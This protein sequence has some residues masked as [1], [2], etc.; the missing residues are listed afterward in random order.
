MTTSTLS[1]PG[2]TA[3]SSA[4]D[5]HSISRATVA[6]SLGATLVVVLALYTVGLSASGY[7]NSFYSA[8]AQA[9]SMSWKAFFFGSLDPGNA[10]TVDKTPGALWIMALSVRLFGLSSWSILLPQALMGVATAAILYITVRRTLSG[11]ASRYAGAPSPARAHWA[12]IVA[13]LAFALTPSATLM[14]RF[15]NPDA[16]M[17]LCYVAASAMTLRA[18]E[19]ASRWKLVG[20]GA[21]VGLGFLAKMLQAF[22]IL[23][24]LVLAYAV[25]APASWRKKVVDLLAAFAAMVVAFGW[26]IAIVELMPASARPYVGGSQ[27]NSVLELTFGYNGLG[28]LNGNET[29]SV[30]G[31]GGTGGRWGTTGISRMFTTVSGEMVSWL[32]PAALVLAVAGLLLLGRRAWATTLRSGEGSAATRTA[33]ALV[34]FTSWLVVN[35]LVFSL[36]AGIYHDYYTVALSPAIAGAFALGG[37]VAWS[38]RDTFVGRLGLA[39]AALATC[40]WGVALASVAGG[41]YLMVSVAAA[42]V[43]LLAAVAFLLGSRLP[44]AL[45]S[46]VVGL[47]VVASLA[48]P[49]AYSLNTAATAHTGSIV[50]A[51][52]ARTGLV[53]TSGGPGSAGGRGMPGQQGQPGQVP[54]DGRIDGRGAQGQAETGPTP[55]GQTGQR[56]AGGGLL[57]GAK[58]SAELVALLQQ[59]AAAYTWTAAT[60]GAQN[61]ASYQLAS[62]TAV[63]AIGGFNGSDPAP[64]LA[65]FQADVAAGRIHYYIAGTSVPS[66]SP[67]GGGPAGMGGTGGGQTGGSRAASEIESWVASTYTATTVGG[68]TVYDLT[69]GR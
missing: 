25:A 58:A 28:R 45:R 31:G 13:A 57:N 26:W 1:A 65:E 52:P 18:A 29:G 2:A 36:M 23:P 20:A 61:A 40:A 66:F 19:T 39:V 69:S 27:T 7:A 59:D 42:A 63:M 10:I 64:T 49:G 3:L 44:D 9:G 50:T 60:T 11:P 12:G 4:R 41:V 6:A 24:S 56:G 47:A 15:N 16:L 38:R 33:G 53:A 46:L 55:A 67:V 21:I 68:A 14:F 43:L 48:G 30:A 17:V 8:A 5:A 22:V 37:A 54:G 32:I 35:G 34:L 51:G 62:E